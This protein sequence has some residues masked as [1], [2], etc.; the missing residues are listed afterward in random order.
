M[1]K[2][3]LLLVL[4]PAVVAAFAPQQRTVSVSSSTSALH[5]FAKGYVGGDGPEPFLIA[6]PENFDPA[7]FCDV[8]LLLLLCY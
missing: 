3:S 8:R 6:K 7:G 4:L 2:V 1:M 5:E